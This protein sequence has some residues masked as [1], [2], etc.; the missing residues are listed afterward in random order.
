M[1]QRGVEQ[2][3]GRLVTDE[4]FREAFFADPARACLR[5]GV[6]LS[7][8]ELDALA[9]IPRTALAE[10]CRRVDD[11]ICRLHIPSSSSLEEQR[12]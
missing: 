4:D 10:L 5:A 2:A 12:S 7:G 1:S 3:L 9:R 6:E 8:G 11:R